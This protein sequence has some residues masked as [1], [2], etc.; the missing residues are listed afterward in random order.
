MPCYLWLLNAYKTVDDLAQAHCSPSLR[1]S[2]WDCPSTRD[3]F[4]CNWLW[5][6]PRFK[7]GSTEKMGEGMCHGE[8]CL[9]HFTGLCL[10][11]RRQRRN[12]ARQS[13]RTFC[14]QEIITA[15]ETFNISETSAKLKMGNNTRIKHF[16]IEGV[17]LK[18]NNYASL[19]Q[20]VQ[21]YF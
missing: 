12:L 2:W 10:M 8:Y 20:A 16:S 17:N 1:S 9:W 7:N 11:C 18:C 13:Q 19:F 6:K 3:F 21:L 5:T 4:R 14:L 15:L